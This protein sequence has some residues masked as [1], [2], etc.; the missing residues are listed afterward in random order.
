MTTTAMTTTTAT[1][2]PARPEH[3]TRPR[4]PRPQNAST[5]PSARPTRAMQR[6]L[7]AHLVG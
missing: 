3:V 4:T 5:G 7:V 1:R 2:T 6:R